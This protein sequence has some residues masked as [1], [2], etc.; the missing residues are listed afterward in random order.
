MHPSNALQIQ[1]NAWFN[2]LL[3]QPSGVR[4]VS[5]LID[6]NIAHPETE[7][8]EHHDSNWRLIAANTTLGQRNETFWKDF[9]EIRELGRS[10]GIDATLDQFRLDALVLPTDG[11]TA[12][13]SAVAGYPI[14]TVPM[15]FFPDD[16]VKAE[17]WPGIYYPA[18]G[19][20][21]GLSFLGGRWKE[22]ELIGLG[23]AYE[24]GT[25]TRLKKLA[26]A[27][28]IPKTQLGDVIGNR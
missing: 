25:R 23:Y 24:Q 11:F 6:Y 5:E 7:S 22:F 20:P 12:G 27:A 8:P 2:S 4:S 16:T 3:V 14:V 21:L 19:I 18:P 15:G 17:R 26:Y 1:L 13:P 10:K 9:A 28:A